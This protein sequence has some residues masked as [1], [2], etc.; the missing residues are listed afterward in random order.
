M[1]VEV[2]GKTQEGEGESPAVMGVL[3]QMETKVMSPK[4]VGLLIR[5]ELVELESIQTDYEFD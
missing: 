2:S 4:Q 3:E 5:E 1:K